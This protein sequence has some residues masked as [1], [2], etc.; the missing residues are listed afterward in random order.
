MNWNLIGLIPLAFISEFSDSSLGMG[1]GIT[2]TPI[3]L[4]LGFEPLEIVPAVLLSEFVSGILAAFLHH[5]HNNVNFTYNS[6]DTKIA[7]ILSA[8]SVIGVII[9]VIIAI[10]IP[11][12]ILKIIISSI[13]ILMGLIIIITLN[14]KPKFSWKKITILGIIASIN[15]GLSGG[16]YGPLVMGGQMLSGIEVKNAVGITS[17]A[18]GI[19]CLTGV[20]LYFFLTDTINW[21]ISPFLVIGAALSVPFSVLVVKKIPEKQF[22]I[23]VSIFI[24]L[25]GLYSLIKTIF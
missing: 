9:A 8:F 13:V 18:E 7:I 25:I 20:I 5:K 23:Y 6:Q 24:L 15:K 16:S 17:L 12:N 4:I 11:E 2:L 3:L 10:N 21:T 22:K 14:Y 19:T 1:F